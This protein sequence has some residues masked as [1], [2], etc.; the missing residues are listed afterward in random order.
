MSVVNIVGGRIAT[1][2]GLEA[3]S[4]F[5]DGTKILASRAAV[6][7]DVGG[8]VGD[9]IDGDGLIVAPGFVDAQIN[10][11]HGIDVAR[12]PERVWEL[13]Q[14]LP[15]HGVTSFLPTII[16][17]P[18]EASEGLIRALQQRPSSFVGAEPLGAHFE[19]PMLAPS[20]RGAHR[21]GMLKDPSPQIIEGW[22][23]KNGVVMVTIA[24]ELPGALEVISELVRRDVIVAVGHTNATSTDAR[25]ALDAG[26]TVVT[27][28]FNAMAP[29]G[30]RDPRLV[31]VALAERDL[32]AG[33]I[34]D[35]I[36]IDPTVIAAAWNAK[37]PGGIML[38]TDAVA[39]MGQE[40]ER[41]EV[42]G[43]PVIVRDGAV[44]D[45]AGNLAGSTLSMDRAVQ[46]LVSYTGCH[47]HEAVI[48]ASTT[49]AR[50]IGAQHRG[51][52]A[53]GAIADLV[54]L[55]DHLDVQVTLCAG[56]VAF[57]ADGARARVPQ[58]L[59]ENAS[60]WK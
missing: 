9:A 37:R 18:A 2:T 20:R 47:V 16:S 17:S 14:R 34:V 58:R 38:V 33:L 55:D 4:V 36:H 43:A 42:A 6:G 11:G 21:I 54:L 22:S 1:A 50:A 3:G 27:H 40:L 8:D 7:G 56:R 32:V 12:E 10:G 45:A 23:R 24:P 28:L 46:N 15:H 13:A 44:R 31:G 5:L 48:A 53:D 52:I 26:A 51:V 57:V 29:L 35:G 39:A 49:P 19:G 41:G 59:I 25:A 30:H 60:S